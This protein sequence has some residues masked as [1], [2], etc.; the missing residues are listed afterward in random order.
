MT[1]FIRNWKRY[2]PAIGILLF[3]Y[4]LV[5]IDLSTVLL[6]IKN[7]NVFFLLVGVFFVIFL[8]LSETTKWFT[9]ARFQGIKIPFIEAFNHHKLD[10]YAY[11]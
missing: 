3:I 4:I 6:E 5:K 9:I 11:F 10:V 1:R 7:V 2:L 8:M